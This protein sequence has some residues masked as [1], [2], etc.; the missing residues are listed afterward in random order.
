MNDVVAAPE[1]LADRPG[2]PADRLLVGHVGDELDRRDPRGRLERLVD[3]LAIDNGDLGPLRGEG[4]GNRPPE[5]PGSP[6][7]DR[8][9]TGDSQVHVLD[10]PFPR[11]SSPIIRPCGNWCCEIRSAKASGGKP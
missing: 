11:G 2:R 10:S 8:D 7:D 5:P 6:H 1:P 4:G 3:Q 9:V